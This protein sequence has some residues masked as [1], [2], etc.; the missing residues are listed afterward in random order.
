MIVSKPLRINCSLSKWDEEI[1]ATPPAAAAIRTAAP[2]PFSNHEV[3]VPVEMAGRTFSSSEHEA[4]ANG[5]DSDS[6][7][8]E[9]RFSAQI[10]NFRPDEDI[11]I[12][13]VELAGFDLF[14]DNVQCTFGR[15]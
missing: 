6:D 8:G 12:S 15:Q 9:Y 1:S 2:S 13:S 10:V 5:L 4:A 11:K 3:P 14:A 7:F